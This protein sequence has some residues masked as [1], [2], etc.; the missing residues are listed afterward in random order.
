MAKQW[1]NIFF[2]FSGFVFGLKQK[3]VKSD[4]LLK[5]LPEALFLLVLEFGFAI[6]SLPMYLLVSPKAVQ[7]DGVILPKAMKEKPQ[8]STY[9]IRR[10]ISLTT[11]FSAGIIFFAKAILVGLVSLYLL[12][13]Q[14]LLAAT[15][16][17][18]FTTATDYT[19]SSS[20]IEF[21]GGVARLKDFGGST[22]GST[23]NSAFNTNSTGW[24]YVQNWVHTGGGTNAGAWQ[25]S[26]G[27]TGGYV[28][29]DLNTQKAK[30]EG[31]YWYQAFTTTVSSPDTATLN[32]DWKSVTFPT[33]LPSTYRLYA[34]IDTVSGNPVTSTAVWDSGEIS[35]TTNWASVAPINITAKIPT[36][37][38]YYVKIA[39]YSAR[40][41]SGALRVHYISGFDNVIVNWSKVTHSYDSTKPTVTPTSSL[42]M[43]KAVSWNSFTETAT[44]NGGEIYYQLSGDNGT[45]W[46]YWTGSAWAVAGGTN[47]NIATDVN[48]NIGTFAT[49]SNQIKFKAFLSSNGTQQVNLDNVDIGY[50]QNMPP[51]VASL[52]PAQNIQNGYVFVN[53]NLQDTESDPSSLVTAEYSLTGAFAGEQ[54]AMTAS[55]TDPAHSGI[56]G[57]TTSPAG[58]SHTFVWDAKSQLGA[59][60]NTT[61]YVRLRANDGV[62]NGAYV[63]S[64]AFTVDYVNPV[65]T[66]VVATE[67]LNTTTVQI[68]YDLADNTSSSLFTDFQVSGDGGS[69]WAVA[70]SS[71]SGAVGSGVTAGTGKIIFWNAGVNYNAHQQAN[72]QV[73]VRAKDAWQ[74][75]GG[76]VTSTNFSLDTL[77]PATLV[78]ADLKAQPNAGDTTVLIGG[79]FT[80]VN[81]STNT[82]YAAVSGGAYFDGGTVGTLNSATPANQAT[83][84]STSLKGNDYISKVKINHTDKYGQSTDNENI[85]PSTSL[86]YVKPYTPAVPTLSNPVTTR[87][88]VLVNPNVSE[89]SGLEYAIYESSTNKYVQSNGTLGASVVWQ[90]LGTSAGQ[91]GNGLVIT[92]QVRVTG[93]SSPV[94]QYIFKVKSRNTSDVA[95]A[96][97][98]ESAFSATAQIPN[99]APSIALNTYAQT[100]DGTDYVT[101]N[102][103]GTDGQGDISSVPTYQYS[104]DNA[105]W[106]T[107]TQKAGVGSSGTS[108]LVFLPTG[109]AYNFVWDSNANLANVETTTA[110]IRLKPNDS[111]I[112]GSV[113]T[114]NAFAIDNKVPVISAVTSS[115]GAGTRTVTFSYTLTDANTSFIDLQ[116]SS[117]GGST[118]TV[119]TSTVSG[120][121]G[122][123]VVPGS[124]KTIT[125]NA[126]TDLNNQYNTNMMVRIRARD[127]FGNQGVY[128]SSSAFTVDTH[129]PVISN[130]T[131]AQNV[132]ADTFTFH[133]DV[134]E[135]AGNATVVLAISSDGGS[136]WA[137]ATSTA[138][139][140]IGSQTP[141]TGKTITWNGAT[142]FN[143]QEKTNMQIRITANDQFNNTSNLASSNFSLDTFVPRVTTVNAIEPL[144]GTNLTVTYSLAD[145]NTS[146]VQMDVSNDGGSTWSVAS[147]SVTGDI[148]SGIIAGS[149]TITW[150]AKTDFPNQQVATM[151]V[152]VR[153]KDIF[154][155]QSANT[156]S[157]AFS[158]DTLNP[159]ILTT[160]DL[161]AQPLAG[162]TVALVGGSFTEV[163][164]SVNLFYVAIDGGAYGTAVTGTANTATPANQ[165][166]AV[167]VTLKGND[168]ISKVK[169]SHTDKY[170]QSTDNENTSPS[171]SFKYVKP[172]TPAVPTVDNPTVGTVDVLINKN[173]SEVDGLQYAIYESSTNKYVQANGTLGASAIW[174]PL[175]V[176]VGNWGEFLS[177]AGKVRVNGLTNASYHY[178]FEVKSRNSSDASH[179]A[180]SESALS[181]GASSANQSPVVILNSVN[182][183]TDGSKWVII[184]YTGSDLESDTSTLIKAE[185]STDNS[186]WH[187]MTEKSG[188]GSNGTSGLSF[189]Y[190]GTAHLF[191]WDVGTDLVNMEDNTVYVR[192]QANDGTS[193][194]NIAASSAFTVDTKNPAVAT[195]VAS[196]TLGL[197]NVAISY[198][199]TDLN[200]STIELNI[201]SDGGSTW[202]VPVTSASGAVGT[203]IAPGNGKSI[204]WNA[205]TDFANQENSTMKVRVRATDSFGNQNTFVTSTNF[206]VD[207]KAP[208]TSNVVASQNI[209]NNFVAVTYDIADAN[210]STVV[211][212]ASSDGGSTWT[213]PVATVSGAV[214]AGVTSGT[215]KTITW[216]A[217]TDFAGQQI[218]N[219]Q[220]RVRATDVY[221]NAG[222]NATSANFTLDTVAP[223]ISNVSAAQVGGSNNFNFT[224]DLFDSGNVIISL[225]ISSDG[226]STWAVATSSLSGAVGSS[227]AP[228]FGKTITWN[229]ATDFNNHQTSNMKIRVRGTDIYNN[230][231]INFLST[232]FNLDTLAP[233]VLTIA[234]LQSQPN[235]GDTTGL[236]G[237]SFTETNPSTNIFVAAINGGTYAASTTG[238]AGTATPANQATGV[239]ATLTGNDFISKVKIV[240]TDNFGHNTINENTSPNTTFKY[241]KPYT[242]DAP[243]VNNPQNTSVDVAV[244]AHA[245]E[246][247]SV[248]YAILETNSNK[249][250]QA[251]GTL[252]SSTVWKTLGIGA[253]QWGNVSGV[254]GKISVTGLV[255][256]VAN[257]SF[258]VKSRNAS[259]AVHAA[260]SESNFSSIVGIT[261]TA[262]SISISSAAQANNTNYVVINY[263]GTDGQN[264]TNNLTS[265][266]YSTDN[267]TW[268]TMTE[269]SGV[270]SNGVSNLIFSSTGT[271]YAFAWD[272]ATDLP[273]TEAPTV[274]VRL[275]SNDNLSSSNL[276]ESSSFTVDTLGP[277]ISNY[278]ISQTPGSQNIAINY[279]LADN[280]GNNNTVVLQI[281]SDGG[282]TWIVPTTTLTGDVGAGI[283]SGAGKSVSW[284]A[285]VDF[286]NQENNLMEVRAISIDRFGNLGN[287]TT[288][289]NF[290]IDTKGPVV[291]AVSAVQM[292]GSTNVAIGYALSDLSGSGNFIDL[293]ISSDG[294]ATW[295]VPTSTL[296]GDFGSGQSTGSKVITWNAGVDFNNH[297]QVNMKVR[298]RGRDY[299][300]NQ[301]SYAQSSNFNLDTRGPVISSVSA[302]QNVGTTSVAISYD[303]ADLT[304]SSINVQLQI[305]DDG[306]ATWTVPTTT[307]TGNVGVGQSAGNGKT[308]TWFA[309]TDFDFQHITNMQVRLRAVD[310]YTNQ[311]IFANSANFA[312]DTANPI[313][314]SLTAS[315][316]SGSNNV[317]IHYD[318]LD[319]SSTNLTVQL[320]ISSDN[321]S[322][323]TI[324]TST[325]VGNIGSSQTNGVGKTIIWNAG[326]DFNNQDSNNLV[327]RAR[328]IDKFTNQGDYAQ[329]ASFAV[330]TKNPTVAIA[331]D[332]SSQPHAGD[333]SV[334]I[335]GSFNE[336]NPNTNY[337]YIAVSGGA[338]SAATTGTGNVSTLTNQVASVGTTL[339]GNDYISKV[340][341]TETDLYNHSANNEN[342]SPNSAIKYVK[343]FTP[344]APTVDNA[345]ASTADVTVNKNPSEVSG[346]EY[347]IFENTSGKYVQT[348]GTLGNTAVWQ[349][350]AIWSTI[351][352]NGLSAPVSQYIFKTK[353]RNSSDVVHAVS[354]ESDLSAG[355]AAGNT[356]PTIT[357]NSAAQV[358]GNNYVIINYEGTD[359]EDNNVNLIT[360]QYS[361]NNTDWFNMTEKSGVGSSGKNNLAFTATGTALTFAWDAGTDLSNLENASV[362]VRLMGNDNVLDG[363]LAGS[364]AFA[365]DLKAPQISNVIASQNVSSQNVTIH[366]DIADLT[367]SNIAVALDISSDNGA[368]WNV[369]TSS[370]VGNIGSSQ[371]SGVD[372]TITWNAGTD[373]N[374]QSGVNMKVR[375]RA[376]DNFA[377]QSGNVQSSIFALDTS[378]PT[379][380][381]ISA[382]QSAGSNNVVVTYD[383]TDDNSTNL[384]VALDISNDNGVTWAVA[385]STLSGN[386]GGSQSAGFGK[387]ITWN[388]GTDFA[389]QFSENF[390]VRL[391]ATDT[392]GNQSNNVNSPIFTVD[393]QAAVVSGVVANQSSGSGVVMVNY[394]LTDSSAFNNTVEIG[395]SDDNGVTWNV[396]STSV[397]GDVGANQNTGVRTFVWNAPID[398]SDQLKTTMK[399]RVRAMDAFGNQGNF[400][401]SAAFNVDTKAPV[402]SSVVA[403]QSSSTDNI[404][405]HYNLAENTTTSTAT[406]EISDD[407][408]LTWT[409]PVTSAIGAVGNVTAGNNKIISWNADTDFSNQEINNMR[410]RLHASDTFG[411]LSSNF[412]SSDFVLDTKAPAGLTTI[413][414]FTSATSSVTLNWSA[415]TDTNFNHFEI[416]HGT[417]QNDVNGRVGSAVKWSTTN[418]SSLSNVLTISTVI[419]GI[420]TNVDYFVKI[421]AVDDY[422]HEV[423]IPSIQVFQTAVVPVVTPA[424]VVIAGGSGF[425]APIIARLSRPILNPII[426]PTTQ[427]KVTISGLADPR[428]KVDLYDN[429]ILIGQLS[430]VTN[431]N[432]EFNQSF[433]FAQGSHSLTVRA[434]DFSNNIS[435]FSDP[436]NLSIVTSLPIVP[437]VVNPIVNT[438]PTS[439]T[440]R[441]AVVAAPVSSSVS[442]AISATVPPASLI[443]IN[444]QAV[445]VPGLPVPQI[446]SVVVPPATAI[447]NAAAG[448]VSVLPANATVND[449]I[450]FTGTALPNQ[451]VVVYIHSDQGL[452]YRAH[453]DS[454]GVWQINHLQS[455][456]ELAPGEHTIFAVALDPNAKVKSRPSPVTIFTVKRNFWVMI[457]QYLNLRTTIVSLVVLGIVGF[458]LYRLRKK[459]LAQA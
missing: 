290:T 265:F 443:R 103:T 398:F 426:S 416:W 407:G 1:L 101:I 301:G 222:A 435:S 246:S 129:A 267:S 240:E 86:K 260:S 107:M 97:S 134:S 448:L 372:K 106:F 274:F 300:A 123:G 201:S 82:F 325:L 423:T 251:N 284:N 37:G 122:A 59:V 271:T 310:S 117:D 56:S 244:N 388:A 375:V 24:T 389:N 309:D 367:A 322:S 10:K 174:Q 184:N 370:L 357:I 227:V 150:N 457:F 385:T 74:N 162:D 258:K 83:T 397:S 199:L 116:V 453:T 371:S 36:A 346:L 332:L 190:P 316:V 146:L 437:S 205:L 132:A 114:S 430:S 231:S 185:Y 39:A 349:T 324:A 319:D 112:D 224:Y 276:A 100:T 445:E 304:T 377:N 139:G 360:Y 50:T 216:N 323:W 43:P 179:A 87:L 128:T 203:N 65:V 343:P 41:S 239:G 55:S 434:I 298:I 438:T 256:P 133:Y 401:S 348:D 5:V 363:N 141:G 331:S 422:G 238:Q 350:G 173:A 414:K 374:N 312:L 53:Y 193:S 69:T 22:S 157:S 302:V 287:Y 111:L 400:V 279:D 95:H 126:A 135:D 40:P 121:V 268:H 286:N 253:G 159:A 42:S 34:F 442:P 289:S 263:T 17:W 198:N 110:R 354:S 411:N 391:R 446:N 178:Q 315:Q 428:T 257:Y 410:V 259:D 104:T 307:I 444:T 6:V 390:R 98:S 228:G 148:G 368:T 451:D 242:P 293:E 305:S 392:F 48:T 151:K 52:V 89:V 427:T 383:L 176:L 64:T 30:E 147:S 96:A 402:I 413:N 138:A 378:A 399:V 291:S 421:F 433:I 170:N 326:I 207:T 236:V 172:Y 125:W 250:V 68:S 344:A 211:L 194:G 26:G 441:P 27:N 405:I 61:V 243:T 333:T 204:S 338:Y 46:K 140:A 364:S 208:V 232:V 94:S 297:E 280:S 409:V 373:F 14:Q 81:P 90:A 245:G 408:G 85:S 31:S 51:S 131:S 175:G 380:L 66:N 165:S 452:I 2:R 356:A 269:K 188:V 28:N 8:L 450:S 436:I 88:D 84:V 358:I 109:S 154:N 366:Y 171:V 161:Q 152:R 281:S 220:V 93:L 119:A 440:V 382:G 311:G 355:A 72:M 387:S 264:D 45:T 212:E 406:L 76:Y 191:A 347:A 180:S 75:Q 254:S 223:L 359:L 38:T 339:Q 102:Y 425:T 145:Q 439:V 230:T 296:T 418:D 124:G 105:T 225:D 202:T 454:K 78:V 130:V 70:T 57:L 7:E 13:A 142:D 15:Q 153:A 394:D 181:A 218:S 21:V 376:I 23:T 210:N 79:S 278:N 209:G 92:G 18:N 163:N 283:S 213:V 306:G 115:Q 362:H 118:W 314:S 330:D 345:T 365:L 221:S 49:S 395:I 415:V 120:A 206:A 166:T 137:V 32:L 424:P 19:T 144:G 182:Q 200:T 196:Q 4:S 226:G 295:I 247:G 429:G 33:D 58:V 285:G 393:T 234:N 187:N 341:I 266:E 419:T 351:T 12:G 353:S 299:F 214:G 80:E 16:S 71:A 149:K 294:G 249:Y 77:A 313:L 459:E 127:S 197:H 252:A 420:P 168:Y 369:A 328:A 229:G 155:N 336:T 73:R 261:N 386:I 192:L 396:A 164:P 9:A 248:E 334:V 54:V 456:V 215:G 340:K 308:I 29:L 379:I 327:V 417:N 189:V 321:G 255:S 20:S 63:T 169:L 292:A 136:T 404:I 282:T 449:V 384:N 320:D 288:S 273:N 361:L 432:G 458:W 317:T 47:F 217:G 183:T 108:S 67:P 219:M 381:N 329:S 277:V 25:S 60:Y 62:Q 342:T 335:A 412:S 113:V 318:L 262:P 237:G 303:L 272:I 275:Q 186:V 235:A 233:S 156:N 447:T 337:L 403:T 35:A 241:V 44:K 195:L 99:T 431:N 352:V 455:D 270:G 3:I 158:L 143:N 167:G 11:A 177:V 160:A 91:W